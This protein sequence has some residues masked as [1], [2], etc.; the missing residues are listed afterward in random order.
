[1]GSD[2][3]FPAR[4]GEDGAQD[5]CRPARGLERDPLHRPR[6]LRLAHAAEGLPPWQTVY[7]WFRR[8]MRHFLFKTIYDVAL[9][10]D[11]ELAGREASP[12]VGVV[13]SQAIKPRRPKPGV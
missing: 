11:R 7:W 10:I 9:M 12:S 3:A 6:W 8:F 1:M 2:R 5:L 13:D 4:A